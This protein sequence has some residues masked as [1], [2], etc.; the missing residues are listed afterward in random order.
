MVLFAN[1]VALLIVVGI[2]AMLSAVAS[3]LISRAH[4]PS[5]RLIEVDGTRLHLD[6]ILGRENEDLAVVLVHGASGNMEDMRIALGDTV[7]NRYRT[8]LV[9]RPG[10]GWSERG[11]DLE[12]ASPQRQADRVAKALDQIG[13][14]RAIIVGHSWGGA[15]ATAFAIRHP[16]R[17]AGLVLL[18]PTSHPWR[19]GVPWYY[20][21]ATVPVLGP[22]FVHTLVI[23]IGA[24]LMRSAIASV[25]DPQSV[26]VEYIK[27]SATMLVLR[28]KAFAANAQDM[29][30]L[31][32]NLERL[33]PDYPSIAAPVVILV[34]DRDLAVSNEVHAFALAKAIPDARLE[35]I[36][37]VGHVPHHAR[38]DRVL[39]AIDE[40]ARL[41]M[42]DLPATTR[43]SDR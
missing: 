33:V 11:S 18:S 37:N 20:S 8:I 42:Q 21:L 36:G 6:E 26:P 15:F 23:P 30:E 17:T 22:L 3:A 13:V 14:R 10:R 9:D 41:P 32:S 39:A 27:R 28:P 34:G 7:G 40:V 43:R 24:L 5:G 29:T 19:G 35:M 16:K 1:L 31:K 38:P 12:E 25:F 2:L 4:P